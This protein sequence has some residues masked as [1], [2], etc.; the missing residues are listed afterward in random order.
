MNFWALPTQFAYQAYIMWF[1]QTT[2]KKIFKPW[3]FWAHSCPIAQDTSPLCAWV[4]LV[5][6]PADNLM[7]KR[8]PTAVWPYP[9]TSRH[10]LWLVNHNNKKLPF[11]FVCRMQTFQTKIKDER[12]TNNNK[13]QRTV[14]IYFVYQYHSNHIT[15]IYDYCFIH[16]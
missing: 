12:Q 4:L 5:T 15:P 7:G 9:A 11:M 16:S 2:Y 8:D 3:I 13:T 10:A 1:Y 14:N 6:R